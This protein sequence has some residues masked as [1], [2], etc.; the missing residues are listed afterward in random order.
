MDWYYLVLISSALMG[1]ENIISKISLRKE[2]ATEFSAAL[3]LI[4]AVISLVVI[5][6]AN[7]N[8]SAMQLVYI[9]IFSILNAYIFL[10]SARVFRHE[11]ISMASPAFSSLP[12]L[13]TVVLAFV[14][15]SE[16]LDL[17]Q[18]I[19]IFGMMLAAYMLLFSAIKKSKGRKAP[20]SGKNKYI[21][22]ILLYS[23]LSAVGFIFSK[24]LLNTVDP[25]AF[26]ILSGI[27]MSL[28]FF[29]FISVKYTGPSEIVNA[30][31]KYKVPLMFNAVLTLGYRLSFYIALAAAPISIAQ[32]FRNVFYLIVTVAIGGMFFKEKDLKRKIAL[33]AFMLIFAY[34][35]TI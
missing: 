29:V 20:L 11:E 31:K 10:L 17:G 19:C 16:H 4:V 22:M 35:L 26:L 34:L 9:I 5:P 3:S 27:F 18:Y 30:V 28:F 7:F 12:T 13:F 32:P 8:I 15:L 14:F 21:Y 24:Y 6:F 23:L 1:L 25:Y 33:S 2:Y